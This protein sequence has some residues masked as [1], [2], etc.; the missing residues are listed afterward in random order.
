VLSLFVLLFGRFE[1]AG[2][3]SAEP[4]A[5]WR[6]VVGALAVCAGLAALAIGG[7]GAPSWPGLRIRAVLA[8]VAG[9]LLLGVLRLSARDRLVP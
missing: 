5:T 3:A 4:P 9:A 2:R 8:T 1:N 6:S 7:I